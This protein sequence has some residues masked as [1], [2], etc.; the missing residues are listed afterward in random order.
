MMEAIVKITN[1]GNLYQDMINKFGRFCP[2]RTEQWSNKNGSYCIG[3]VR[4]GIYD[5]VIDTE[6]ATK[7]YM[8][9]LTVGDVVTLT[10]EPTEEVK[11]ILNQEPLPFESQY[12][13]KNY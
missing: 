5:Y 3:F 2:I 7:I 4:V 12:D 10:T 6:S 9:T 11:R 1:S 8:K 13:D